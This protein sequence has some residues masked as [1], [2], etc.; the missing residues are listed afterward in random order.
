MI[1]KKLQ[2]NVS[3]RTEYYINL[4][5]EIDKI[6]TSEYIRKAIENQLEKDIEN[7]NIERIREF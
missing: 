4:V 6:T 3:N 7:Y 5:K 1:N 2:V